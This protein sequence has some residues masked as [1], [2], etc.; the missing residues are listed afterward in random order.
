MNN[1][2]L[3]F[4]TEIQA[5]VEAAS[6]LR[7]SGKYEPV[8][9]SDKVLIFSPH[10]DDE[11]IIGLLPLRLMR[12]AG[13]QVINIPVT[14]GSDEARQA[15]RAE[16]LNNAC[17]YLGWSNYRGP[18]CNTAAQPGCYQ[19]LEKDD[20]VS[21]LTEQQPRV[22]LVPH[23][24]DWNSRHISTHHLVLEALAEM[25]FDFTCTV[26]ETEFWGAMWS[27]NLMVEADAE[28]LAD[29]VAATSLHVEEVA[30]NPYHLLLPAWMQDNV[31]R[32]G[33]LVGG[34]GGAAPNFKFATLYRLSRWEN[35]A[36]TQCT[37]TSKILGTS[38]NLTE[39]F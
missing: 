2:Y 12:E 29:L 3:K 27:P 30:R 34:Q 38:D 23:V 28:T 36:F 35:K 25:P 6:S 26:V 33:E 1:P 32:G 39:I 9:S 11:C 24:K 16:E 31:R 17:N 37:D 10:P 14:Y 13:M 19:A 8:V 21:I 4:V 7:V 5:N 22:I 18:E 15:G 20:I